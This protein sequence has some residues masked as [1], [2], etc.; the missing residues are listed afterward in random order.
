MSLRLQLSLCATV[1][2]ALGWAGAT[3]AQS[4]RVDDSA[5]QVLQSGPVKMRWDSLVPRPGEP[6]TIRGQTTVLVRLDVSPWQGRNARIYQVLAP[7]PSGPVTVK[8]SASG[9]LLPGTVRDGERSLVYSGPILS[10]LFQDTFVLTIEA[11][12]ERVQR[13]QDL[14]FYFEIELET[15]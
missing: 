10:P 15:P 2:L 11:N 1:L 3:A 5:S 14:D 7:V 13:P 8:W 9:P 4:H 12:G 6:P